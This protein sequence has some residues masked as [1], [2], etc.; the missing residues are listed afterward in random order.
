MQ[1]ICQDCRRDLGAAC[2]HCKSLNVKPSHTKLG[3][4]NCGNCLRRDMPPG[5]KFELVCASCRHRRLKLSERHGELKY[6]HH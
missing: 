3:T 1:R 4:F 5:E 2:D 6:E